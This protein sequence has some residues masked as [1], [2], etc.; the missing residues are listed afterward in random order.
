MVHALDPA[1]DVRRSLS[2]FCACHVACCISYIYSMR[3]VGAELE[4][5]VGE[6]TYGAFRQRGDLRM[7]PVLSSANSTVLEVPSQRSANFAGRRTDR[8]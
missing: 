3:Q 6:E 2:Q 7:S 4:A 5:V 8:P 1:V